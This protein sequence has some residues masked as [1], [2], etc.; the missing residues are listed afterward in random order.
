MT[1]YNFSI[2]VKLLKP[3][4]DQ[5]SDTQWFPLLANIYGTSTKSF[6]GYVSS[7]V[8]SHSEIM[9]NCYLVEDSDNYEKLEPLKSRYS[10]WNG[11]QKI[12]ILDTL[13]L[14]LYTLGYN[15][16]SIAIT[17]S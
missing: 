9:I 16:S 11:Y 10:D 5:A 15:V 2:T 7:I 12:S 14:H 17:S 13:K 1:V 3:V 8:Y 4:P 6:D